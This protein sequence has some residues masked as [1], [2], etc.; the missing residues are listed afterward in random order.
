MDSHR[1]NEVLVSLRSREGRREA[2][3]Q[4]GN[5]AEFGDTAAQTLE[6]PE[7][8]P[9]FQSESIRTAPDGNVWV[10]RFGESGL[11]LTY[12]V[13]DIGGSIVK[14]VTLPARRRLIGF[15]GSTLYAVASD[16]AADCQWIERYAR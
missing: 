13:F 1:R 2:A 14:R 5:Y 8:A 6:W 12:D 16:V 10:E 9:P 4:R 11:A 3:L 15:G 7:Y